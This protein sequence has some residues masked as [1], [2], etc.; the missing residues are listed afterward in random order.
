MGRGLPCNC[1][2]TPCPSR[3]CIFLVAEKVVESMKKCNW[4]EGAFSLL[5]GEGR[6]VGQSLVSN[7]AVKAVGFTGSR[8]GG[9]ALFNLAS[10]RPEPIPVF[11]EMSSINPLFVLSEMDEIKVED[12]SSGLC[13]SATLGVGQFCTNPGIVFHPGGEWGEKFITQYADKMK[14]VS[15]SPML[16]SG[17]KD[18]FEQGLKALASC[19][20]VELVHRTTL[21]NDAEGSFAG[22]AVLSCCGK[23]FPR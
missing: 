22:P 3:D 23:D 14:E 6:T 2:G 21:D 7:P 8:S 12:F 18:A 11:A 20:G 17:I 13:G 15:A 1:Q 4:P 16:H 19:E 5:Y 10:Q 9:R